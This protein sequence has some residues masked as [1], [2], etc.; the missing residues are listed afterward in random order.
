MNSERDE[1]SG[2]PDVK[3]FHHF[4]QHQQH[5]HQHQHCGYSEDNRDNAKV[6]VSSDFSTARESG[7]DTVDFVYDLDFTNY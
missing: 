5:Q 4:D 7:G 6:Y 2:Q 3:Q 1:F